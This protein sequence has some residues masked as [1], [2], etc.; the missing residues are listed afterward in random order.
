M[1]SVSAI[2][3]GRP[4]DIVLEEAEQ[5]GHDWIEIAVGAKP[6]DHIWFWDLLLNTGFDGQA[7]FH[8]TLPIGKGVTLRP[9][10]NQ[11]YEKII[12]ELTNHGWDGISYSM[13]P[14]LLKNI[15]TW[16]HFEDW[17]KHKIEYAGERNIQVAF[18]NMYPNPQD[19]LLATPVGL[20]DFMHAVEELGYEVEDRLVFDVSHAHIAGWE[21]EDFERLPDH[22]IKEFHYSC[23]D[24][25]RDLHQRYVPPSWEFNLLQNMP[26]RLS[27][28]VS[29]GVDEGRRK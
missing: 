2:G 3:R 27:N 28:H 9:D 12:D 7:T 18:E 21:I 10:S 19:H 29:M 4:L 6:V 22:C 13:H 1:I 14:P 15:P 5:Q 23:N 11:Q 8:H 26:H 20:W 16:R 17:I 25:R 24:G